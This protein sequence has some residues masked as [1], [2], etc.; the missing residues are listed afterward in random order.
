MLLS[1]FFAV[2]L[3]NLVKISLAAVIA[4]GAQLFQADI[5]CLLESRFA[6]ILAESAL[7]FD[8]PNASRICVILAWGGHL[9]YFLDFSMNHKARENKEDNCFETAECKENKHRQLQSIV[10]AVALT[11][12]V[13][14]VEQSA[15]DLPIEFDEFFG[16]CCERHNTA[17]FLG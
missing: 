15:V 10:F 17:P 4:G 6:A 5:T 11:D 2:E 7:T 8:R 16:A 1:V 14:E 9:N 3:A 13:R 12:A